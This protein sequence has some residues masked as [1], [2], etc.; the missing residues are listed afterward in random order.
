MQVPRE[1][2]VELIKSEGVKRSWWSEW[3]AGWSHVRQE[4]RIHALCF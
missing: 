2:T 1:K 4:K 3:G